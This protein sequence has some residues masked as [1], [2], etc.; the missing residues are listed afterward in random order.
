MNLKNLGY[1]VQD[2]QTV[3]LYLVFPFHRACNRIPQC[4][5]GL[6]TK[7]ALINTAVGHAQIGTFF[8]SRAP[9]SRAKI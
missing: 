3:F 8:G 2:P 4:S 1:T 6:E 9:I 5:E 7:A